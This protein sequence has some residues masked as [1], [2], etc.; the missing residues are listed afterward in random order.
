MAGAREFRDETELLTEERPPLWREGRRRC[1]SLGEIVVRVIG[2][3][4]RRPCSP[5]LAGSQREAGVEGR[6]LRER[7]SDISAEGCQSELGR[8]RHQLLNVVH[9]REIDAV[10]E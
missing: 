6:A 10:C 2:C 4:E 1:V 5:V 8:E 3:E 9:E 7:P